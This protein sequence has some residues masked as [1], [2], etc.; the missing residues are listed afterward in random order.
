MRSGFTS[1][2]KIAALY[3]NNFYIR[4]LYYPYLGQ[5]NHSVGGYFK[6]GIWH[7]SKFT[8][9][10]KIKDK[11]IFIDNLTVNAE[12]NWDNIKV[13]FSD[14]AIF[15]H[16]A[17]IRK[18]DVKGEGYVRIIFYHDFKL[19][20]NE[21]GDTAFY[22]PELDSVLHYKDNTWFLIGSSHNLYEYTMGR[23]DKNQVIN[24]CEDG[25]LNKNAI[26]QGSVA[27]AISIAYPSFYYFIIAEETFDH[28]VKIYKELKENPDFHYTKN[29][30][31][32]NSITSNL[33]DRLAKLSLAIMLGHVGDN[34]AIPASLDTDILKFNLDTYAYIWPRDAALTAN[35]LDIAGYSSFTR[36][37]YDLVFH[38]LFENG[39]L[40]QKYNPD[41]T[42][43]STWHSWTV[44]SKRSFNIQEDETSTVLWAFW[45]YFIR[46][47]DYDMLKDVYHIIRESANFMTNFRDEK[48][49]LPLETYD[50]WE[51]KLGVHTYTVSSVYAG[52]KAASNFANVVGD[53]ENVKKWNEAAEEIKNSLK[54][55]MFDKERGVFYKFVNIDDGKITSVDKTVESSILGIVIFDVFDINDPVVSS[56]VNQIINKLWV[57][58]VGGLA[59]YENDYY[60]RIEG[61]YD[62][63]PGN[64]W[65]I[66]TMWLAQYYVKK[67]DVNK[68][69]DLLNW[70][71]KYSVSGLLPE[72]LNPF[73]GSPLS[74]VPLLWSHAEYLKTYLMLK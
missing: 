23:R 42:W 71:N 47:K 50:L 31:Y 63:I 35:V 41:G 46:S 64:P 22:D 15:S 9:I 18:V 17:I 65:I 13:N 30:Y 12:I 6:I 72:Q 11:K 14:V 20:G 3:D 37:F 45:N 39:Y 53:E 28:V 74:V 61:N 69:K 34:G 56:S 27:S 16:S 43:G 68:A 57:K 33:D 5:Y 51:E 32:W 1:N 67:G 59:R 44:R 60:Q 26:A 70:A 4:E 36:K 10:D 25:T 40:F 49:K 52:L 48:L 2:G 62:S 54:A 29:K 19:N 24:D 21:I 38:K 7:N 58:N 55:N 66:T 8:W 73:D